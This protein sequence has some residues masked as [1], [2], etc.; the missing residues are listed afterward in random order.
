MILPLEFCMDAMDCLKTR[1]NLHDRSMRYENGGYPDFS[2]DKTKTSKKL[3]LS[4]R[5]NTGSKSEISCVV[6][7]RAPA[8]HIDGTTVRDLTSGCILRPVAF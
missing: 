4:K 8:W 3:L 7:A 2:K 6:P 1:D 5:M